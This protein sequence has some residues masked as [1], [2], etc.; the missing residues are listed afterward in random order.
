MRPKRIWRD[1]PPPRALRDQGQEMLPERMETL[2]SSIG[3]E[4]R[5][6]TTT[7]GPVPPARR[8][9]SFG[10]PP[11]APLR[12]PPARDYERARPAGELVRPGLNA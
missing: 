12:N 9:A 3:R 1:S 11:L 10:A 4:T 7:Y 2:I 8:T 6:R 5:Q